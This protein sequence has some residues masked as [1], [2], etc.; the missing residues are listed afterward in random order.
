MWAVLNNALKAQLVI[1]PYPETPVQRL[2]NKSSSPAT[3]LLKLAD[4]VD[5][6]API[7][8]ALEQAAAVFN[9]KIFDSSEHTICSEE[10]VKMVG[11]VVSN[12]LHTA[13]NVVLPIVSA[14][15][16]EAQR[17]LDINADAP[18]VGMSIEP[19]SQAALWNNSIL[20]ELADRYAGVAYSGA[21]A[22]PQ[23]HEKEVSDEFLLTL[24]HQGIGRL[25]SDIDDWLNTFTV[26]ELRRVYTRVFAKP[27]E[28]KGFDDGPCP[29]DTHISSKVTDAN[30][31]IAVYLMASGLERGDGLSGVRM[32]LDNYRLAIALV[33]QQAGLKISLLLKEIARVDRDRQMVM[34]YPAVRSIGGN[35]TVSIVVVDYLYNQWLSDGG[36]PEILF[37]AA[38][39]DR[40]TDPAI[41]LEKR[42]YYIGVWTREVAM[43]RS[44]RTSTRL[45]VARRCIKDELTRYVNEQVDGD[46]ASIGLNK[47]DQHKRIVVMADAMTMYDLDTLYSC[48]RKMVCAILF[49]HTDALMVLET[50]DH[51]GKDNP[52]LPIREV[53]LLATI[54]I[55]V[56]WVFK[57]LVITG[58]R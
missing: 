32:T 23:W 55:L 7:V 57:Q 46:L 8:S 4:D 3:D 29:L 42:E 47:G 10:M 43:M 21:V 36:A 19:L 49:P 24:V 14:I 27:C 37:G 17:V 50:I 28:D 2:V 39:S 25:D 9:P 40:L 15:A 5:R 16:T 34:S 56:K 45:A 53:A 12:N 13:K 51:I 52:E 1:T 22:C 54:D 31:T 11:G 38:L 35:T 6:V 33:K 41:L 26:A 44:S 18:S 58:T 48:I 20:H 30:D